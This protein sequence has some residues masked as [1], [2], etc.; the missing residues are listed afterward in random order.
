MVVVVVVSLSAMYASKAA[1]LPSFFMR[2]SPAWNSRLES[3]VLG[4]LGVME[5]LEPDEGVWRCRLPLP[6]PLP[7]SGAL[8]ACGS[9]QY[10][11]SDGAA[12]GTFV[13]PSCLRRC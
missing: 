8:V 12:S 11:I 7:L 2:S 4:V 3:A 9:G 5:R 10:V 6:L 1:L 13:S